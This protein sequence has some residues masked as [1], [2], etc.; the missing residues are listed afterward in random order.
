MSELVSYSATDPTGG[1][2][3]A[4][5]EAARA[6]HQLAQSLVRT[7]IVP[8]AFR[9][10]TGMSPAQAEQVAADATAALLLGDEVGLTPIASLRALYVIRGQVGMY[11]RARVA[12]V[13][14]RGHSI[15]TEKETDTEVTVAGHRAGEPDH[16]ERSTWTIER[17]DRAGFIRRGRNGELSQYDTQPRAMLYARAASDVANRIAPD[18]LM[19]I[20]EDAEEPTGA[21][22]VPATTTVQRQPR[23]PLQVDSAPAARHSGERGAAGAVPQTDIT[24]TEVVHN[25]PEAPALPLG[26]PSPQEA[27][28][29][30]TGAQRALLHSLYKAEG[31]DR[32]AYL[33]DASQLVGRVLGSTNELT[34]QEASLLIDAHTHP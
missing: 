2:L 32:S 16:V 30:M 11:A 22:T 29:P 21:P 34:K 3:V 31:L 4:W 15:W 17:A 19:G 24:P 25:P 8:E 5:A 27:S 20:P 33:A 1:R 18:A 12:L 9:L 14:A 26:D 10:K 28:E 13:K 6:A 23:R 7:T